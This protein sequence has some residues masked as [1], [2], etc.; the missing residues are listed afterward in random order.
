MNSLLL[1]PLLG[2]NRQTL[3]ERCAELVTKNQSDRFLYLAASRPLLEIVTE[4][5]LDG[6]R[7]GG[8]WGELPVY[9][10]RGFVRYVLANAVDEEGKHLP[11]MLPIDRD[12]LPLKRSL[13]S[14]ILSQLKGAGKLT[15][16]GPLAGRDGCVNSIST[17]IGELQR[18]AKS[19]SEV[20]AIIAARSEDL[21]QK[22]GS[23]IAQIDFDNEVA[24]I[25][26]C[27][28]SLLQ[29][30]QLTERDADQLRALNV[31]RSE[32]D[33]CRV[34]LPLL[35]QVELLILDGFFDFTPVQGEILR[36]LIPRIPETVVNLN[37]DERNVE[38]FGPFQ[39]T[40]DQL[41]GISPFETVLTNEFRH[42]D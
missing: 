7:N 40:I 27:Y 8:V 41:Q 28:C 6:T 9:L 3:I 4:G 17:L 25:Y 37:Y 20:S 35:G 26:S 33:G 30:N 34:R 29:S 23:T 22:S 19:P 31:L 14:Q 10:F 15:A 21:R 24:L 11:P 39:E 32:V 16:I 38:I 5:I 1:G 2:N 18:T 12:E 13:V 42:T 36:E